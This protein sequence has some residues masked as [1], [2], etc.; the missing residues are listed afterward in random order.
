M[1]RFLSH[2]YSHFG[3]ISHFNKTRLEMRENFFIEK[4]E[5]LGI[6]DAVEAEEDAEE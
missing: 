6:L 5:D 1:N 4:L 2:S 3:P